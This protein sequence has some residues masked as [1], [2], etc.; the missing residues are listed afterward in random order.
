MGGNGLWL[1]QGRFRV[2]IMENFCMEWSAQGCGGVPILEGFNWCVDV[3]LGDRG[4]GDQ[5]GAAG[6]MVGLGDLRSLFQP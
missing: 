5:G 6:L 2:D 4:S 3:A 1:H